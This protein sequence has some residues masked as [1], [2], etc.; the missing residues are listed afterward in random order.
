MSTSTTL[1]YSIMP[2]HCQMAACVCGSSWD[3]RHG[4]GSGTIA[5]LSGGAATCDRRISCD[6]KSCDRIDIDMECLS[7]R[8]HSAR[9]DLFRAEA[10]RT[11]RGIKV[12]DTFHIACEEI[13][14]VCT[15]QYTRKRCRDFS[16]TGCRLV[17]S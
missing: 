6:E 16:M 17:G 4:T 13:H 12:H 14:Y 15:N 1:V 8:R 2:A 7:R 10:G 5:T 3:T 9:V 11:V